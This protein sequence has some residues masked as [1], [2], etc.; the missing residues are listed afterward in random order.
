ML[1][2]LVIY[3]RSIT[4][5]DNAEDLDAVMPMQNLIE[6]SKNYENTTGSLWNYYRDEPII[7]LL[8]IMGCKKAVF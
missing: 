8:I 1:H 7:L 3:Q 2:L 4:L 6:Y 5:I